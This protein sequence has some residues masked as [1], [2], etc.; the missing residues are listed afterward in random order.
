MTPYQVITVASITEKEGYYT[1]NMPKVARVI[2]NR[3][4]QGT[5]LQMDSTVLYAIGQDGGPVTSEDLK[6]QSPYNTYL[7]KG[8]TPTPICMPS[9]T[10]LKS[11]PQPSAGCLAVFRAGAEERR[12]GVL[13]HVRRAAGQR[14]AGEIPWP[15]LSLA[16]AQGPSRG[17]WRRLGPSAV[18]TPASSG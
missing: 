3:L 5:A 14:A 17:R 2:Y 12:H 1:F 4:A 13:R 9:V 18:R 11:R 16:A 6:I 8:L 10:A 15:P 7:N